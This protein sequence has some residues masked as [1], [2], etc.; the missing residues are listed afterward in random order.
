MKVTAFLLYLGASV[1]LIYAI[2]HGIDRPAEF[3]P[4][5][6]VID[7]ALI[8]AFILQHSLMARRGVNRA[9]YV[10]VSSLAVA[11]MCLLWQPL[12]GVV[13]RLDGAARWGMWGVS[14]AAWIFTGIANSQLDPALGLWKTRTTLQTSGVYRIV[15]HPAYLGMIVALWAA[16]TMTVA[17]LAFAAA[18]TIYVVVVLPL[19][20]RELSRV[21]GDA[22]AA[23]CARVPA[24]IPGL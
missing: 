18:L 13:W 5:A 16:E 17:H 11:A 14:A 15:R 22:W 7:A 19:E 1:A 3:T 4:R 6:A 9:V 24:L 10:L 20:E 12:G 21:Y 8:A 23:Y 2:E